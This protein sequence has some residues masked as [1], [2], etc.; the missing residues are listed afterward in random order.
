[1]AWAL[2]STDVWRVLMDATRESKVAYKAAVLMVLSAMASTRGEGEGAAAD[3]GVAAGVCEL[4][5]L[6]HLDRDTRL[7][8]TSRGKVGTPRLRSS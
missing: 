2:A 4:D 3:G 8:R 6:D 1:M 7:S 5:E